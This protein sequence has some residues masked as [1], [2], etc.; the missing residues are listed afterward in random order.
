MEPTITGNPSQRNFCRSGVLPPRPCVA[1]DRGKNT[2][3]PRS[4]EKSPQ[5]MAQLVSDGAKHACRMRDGG[6]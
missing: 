6:T 4:S 2:A 3:K 1:R 5:Q